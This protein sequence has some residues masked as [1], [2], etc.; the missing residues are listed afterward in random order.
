M[1]APLNSADIQPRQVA[2]KSTKKALLDAIRM[3]LDVQSAAVRLNTQTFNR[4]RYAAT[5]LIADYDELKDRARQIKENAIANL[6]ELLQQ[7]EASVRANGGHFYLAKTA[8]DANA[9]IRDVLLRHEVK[10]VVKGKSITSEET[11][12]NHELEAAGLT[13]A[14]TD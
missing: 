12:L 7:L 11:K 13:V 9:Y 5:A 14:E 10:L 1:A 2:N 3:T 6:P 8:A 4:N